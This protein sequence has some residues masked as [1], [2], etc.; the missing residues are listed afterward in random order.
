MSQSVIPVIVNRLAG[1]A[2]T[3]IRSRI[4]AAFAASGLETAI[5]LVSGNEIAATVARYAGMP[6][7]VIGGGDGTLGTALTARHG[8]GPIGL[9][10][11]GTRN[12]LARDLGVPLDLAAAA[13]MIAGGATRAIDLASVNGHGFVNNASVGLY[14]LMVRSRDAGARRGLPKWLATI[15]AAWSALRRFPEH[16]MHLHGNAT[17]DRDLLTP[18]LFVGN[19]RYALER[20]QVGRRPALDEGIL[21]VFAVGVHSRWSL[22]WFALRVLLGRSD[23]AR[24]FALVGECDTLTVRSRARAIDIALDGEVR[25]LRPPL[26]FAIMPGAVHVCAP[27]PPS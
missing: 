3:P 17:P 25:R 4:E 12:H 19:N 23:P 24:D 15:P 13:A 22:L 9:L 11:L 2:E 26:R 1:P 7:I 6:L 16:R 27:T 18:L 8:A 20:G 14:P 21:S 5:E 10:A